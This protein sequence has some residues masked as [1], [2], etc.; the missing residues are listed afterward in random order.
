MRPVGGL[1]GGLRG[2]ARLR[3]EVA[4]DQARLVGGEQTAAG[5]QEH[6]EDRRDIAGFGGEP[7]GEGGAL[8]VLHGDEDLAVALA[9]FVDLDDVRVGQA[10]QRLGL[11]QQAGVVGG[12]QQLDRHASLE[13]LVVGRIDHAHPALAEPAED[14]EVAD[15]L[16]LEVGQHGL[17]GGLPREPMGCAQGRVDEHEPRVRPGAA[18]GPYWRRRR[19]RTSSRPG[20]EFHPPACAR[21]T[22]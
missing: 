20:R 15:L 1:R 5:L 10:G 19:R 13:A 9:D 2:S 7:G 18:P 17:R 4:V 11:A 14:R 6:L 12:V 3:L 16:G 8:D 21:R 22:T